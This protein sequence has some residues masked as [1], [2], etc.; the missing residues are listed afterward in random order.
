V[1]P[2]DLI[3]KRLV[4]ASTQGLRRV[5]VPV[6]ELRIGIIEFDSAMESVVASG[7][8][9]IWARPDGDAAVLSEAVAAM[10]GYFINGTG[11]HWSR[12]E[13]RRT[14]RSLDKLKH[15][16]RESELRD[17][18]ED[19]LSLDDLESPVDPPATVAESADTM[20][21]KG[22][23]PYRDLGLP[24]PTDIR[25][26]GLPWPP[27]LPGRDDLMVMAARERRAVLVDRQEGRDDPLRFLVRPEVPPEPTRSD[28][29]PGCGGD[30]LPPHAFCL[31]CGRWGLDLVAEIKR[32]ELAEEV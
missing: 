24:R 8:A 19:I 23:V 9:A 1:Q 26:S 30:R 16:I 12:V 4:V 11:A 18:G 31:P 32:R 2:E 15:A 27:A 5:A 29:C 28:R 21:E 25:G 14:T 7:F 20:G 6:A 22:D 13:R 3:R 10:L 17:S